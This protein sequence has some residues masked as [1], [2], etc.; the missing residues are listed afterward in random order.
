[1]NRKDRFSFLLVALAGSTVFLSGCGEPTT[2]PKSYNTL[3]AADKSF[4]IDYPA[5]WTADSGG[6]GGYAWAKFTS[7]SSEISVNANVVGSLMGDLP[8]MPHHAVLGEQPDEETAPVAVVHE[9]ERETFEEDEDV[10]EKKAEVVKTGIQEARRAEFTGERT[11]GSS[12]HGYRVTALT[13]QR[14]IRVVCQCP[15]G[16]WESLKPAFDKIVESLGLGK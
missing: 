10:K 8:K 11:L 7:G 3:V 15:E 13:T 14:R 12:V 5:E 6:K 9:Q 4:K 16:E 2:M 1:M